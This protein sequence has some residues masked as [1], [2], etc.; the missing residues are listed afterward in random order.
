MCYAHK[1]NCIYTTWNISNCHTSDISAARSVQLFV[2]L[3]R[4]PN[5]HV[6]IATTIGVTN[7][8]IQKRTWSEHRPSERGAAERKS[9]TP[10]RNWRH[11][12]THRTVARWLAG[13]IHTKLFHGFTFNSFFH[14][15]IHSCRVLA[16]AVLLLLLCYRRRS[17]CGCRCLLAF[18]NKLHSMCNQF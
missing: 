8:Y 3:K 10:M 12:I 9:S 5:L 6:K 11:T 18:D 13:P 15:F 14:S 4:A 2:L 7:K 16:H 17:R 1:Q